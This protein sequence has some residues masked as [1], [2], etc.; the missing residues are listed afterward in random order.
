MFS[1]RWMAVVLAGVFSLAA[2]TSEPEPKFEAE[3]SQ[4][5]TQTAGDSVSASPTSTVSEQ[6]PTSV[7]SAWVQAR[8]AALQNGNTSGVDR[9]SAPTCRS[10]EELNKVIRQIYEAGGSFSTSGWTISSSEES[11]QDGSAEVNA[12][13]VVAGGQTLASSGA[14]PVSYGEEKHIVTF[15]LLSVKDTFVVSEVLFR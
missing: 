14:E 1:S 7:V 9:L 5:A 2:C 15:R 11:V 8:N 3:P 6:G 10:C 13:I 12:A 4:S